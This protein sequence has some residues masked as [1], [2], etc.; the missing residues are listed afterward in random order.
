LQTDRE[1][2]RLFARLPIFAAPLRLAFMDVFAPKKSS[3][4][5][6]DNLCRGDRGR[7]RKSKEMAETQNPL[8]T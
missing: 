7:V 1:I 4:R 6:I 5:E 8:I 2:E 3:R